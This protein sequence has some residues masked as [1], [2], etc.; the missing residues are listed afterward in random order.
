MHSRVYVRGRNNKKD[1]FPVEAG[2]CQACVVSP[3]LFAV[4]MDSVV[5]GISSRLL[6]RGLSL[7]SDDV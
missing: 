4:Y 6:S 1:R 7:M 3:W 5:R 2:L